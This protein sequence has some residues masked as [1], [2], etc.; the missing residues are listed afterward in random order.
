MIHREK[1]LAESRVV[2]RIL[3]R[4]CTSIL[5]VKY[6]VSEHI[7]QDAGNSQV[8][9]RVELPEQL[10][11]A[12]MEI[13]YGNYLPSSCSLCA[14]RRLTSVHTVKVSHKREKVCLPEKQWPDGVV[15][16]AAER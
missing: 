5:G 14:K 15:A 12:Y 7:G 4:S 3:V 2:L 8:S 11:L 1:S 16:E 6:P 9:K 10:I 13:R